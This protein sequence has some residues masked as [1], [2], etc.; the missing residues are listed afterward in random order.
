MEKYKSQLTS[1]VK[2]ISK[3]F[4]C[5]FIEM[6]NLKKNKKLNFFFNFIN[7]CKN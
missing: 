3:Q 2:L 1:I 7:S 4:L 6:D 5:F